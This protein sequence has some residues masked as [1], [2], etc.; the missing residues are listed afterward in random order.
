MGK[1]RIVT[2]STADLPKSLV[3]LILYLCHK[4]LWEK[5]TYEDGVTIQGF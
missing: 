2:D 3:N 1:V 4:V 5:E